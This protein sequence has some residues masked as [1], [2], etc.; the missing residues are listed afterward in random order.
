M[1]IH[2]R[3]F[4]AINKIARPPL[5]ILEDEARKAWPGGAERGSLYVLHAG[6]GDFIYQWGDVMVSRRDAAKKLGEM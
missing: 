4:H 3:L 1:N 2:N 6:G 5:D